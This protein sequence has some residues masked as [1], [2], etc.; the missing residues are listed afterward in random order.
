MLKLAILSIVAFWLFGAL[1]GRRGRRLIRDVNHL[2]QCIVWVL[3]VFVGFTAMG[4]SAWLNAHLFVRLV[5]AAAWFFAAY[6]LAGLLV[7]Q[8]A[9][10]P[11]R[12]G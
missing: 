12:K 9:A 4:Q 7:R 1:F 8:A 11:R 10:P 2:L 3:L 5:L 6:R